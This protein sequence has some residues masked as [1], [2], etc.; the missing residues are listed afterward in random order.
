MNVCQILLIDKNKNRKKRLL[1][2]WVAKL[3][4]FN[5]SK[6]L[7]V[8]DDIYPIS[9]DMVHAVRFHHLAWLGKE[10]S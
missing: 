6:I 3:T 2:V 8:D 5:R 4:A 1:S 9:Y 10:S 7:D